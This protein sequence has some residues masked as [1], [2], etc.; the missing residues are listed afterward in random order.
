M[1]KK[2]YT[3]YIILL[4]IVIQNIA[5][6]QSSFNVNIGA[7][8]GNNGNLITD[9][10]RTY[11]TGYQIG[12]TGNFGTYNFFISPGVF[13]KD[14]TINNRFNEIKP[15][16]KSPRIKFAKAKII[17]GYQTN[18]ITKKIKFRIG[19]GINGNYIINI[20][21]NNEDF[22]INTLE[23]TY[24]A[25]NFDIGLDFFILSFNL[26]YEKSVKNV[27][28]NSVDGNKF[29]FLILSAGVIF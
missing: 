5:I 15:F 10:L 14:I 13:F 19:G 6:G 8:A 17:I 24:L 9:S 3:K 23:D 4:M 11:R 12:V 22:S 26:S 18:L 1:R 29:D 7:V 27:L 16:V 25:Y 2:L 28:T 20:N 21:D